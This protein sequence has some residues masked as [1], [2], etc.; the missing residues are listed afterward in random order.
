M[1]PD[2]DTLPEVLLDLAVPHEDIGELVGLCRRVRGDHEVR[3]LLERSVEELVKDMGGIRGVVELPGQS[4]MPGLPGPPDSADLLARYFTVYIC[5]AALPHIRAHHRALGIA[6]EVTRH[7]LSDVG[8]A[9]AWHRRR[10]GTGGVLVPEWLSLHFHGELY[11]L[12]RLQFQRARLGRRTG[13]ALASAGLLLRP[14]D[15]C[16]SVHV[17]DFLGPLSPEACDRSLAAAREFCARHYPEEPYAV[18]VC[19]SWLLDGQL[20]RYLPAGSNIVRFQERFRVIRTSAEP[21][22]STTIRF[23]FGDPDLPVERLPRRTTL[24]RAVAD[25]LRAGGHWHVGHGWFPLHDADAD[26]DR[27]ADA[28]AARSRAHSDG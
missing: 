16:L 25:H 18:A 24:E 14:G 12:G 11:Q 9:M 10:Y 17:P 21:E 27:A 23:V 1:L 4:G 2:A 22:D 15:P 26:A 28:G 5:A 8:R 7:T 3:R 13:A 19:S 20:K 6:P